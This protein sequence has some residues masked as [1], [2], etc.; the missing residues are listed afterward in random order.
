MNR[1]SV[2][3]WSGSRRLLRE[4]RDLMKAESTTQVRLDQV[5]AM[6]ASDMVAEVC[7]VYLM[8]AGEV[9]ELYAS[10]G[11]K[12]EAV[13]RTR[14][15]LGEG[16]VGHIALRARPVALADAQSH[17][18][19]AYRPETGEEIYHS[20][21]GVPLLRDNRVQGVLVVQNVTARSY[22]EEEV[23]ALETVAMVLSELIVSAGILTEDETRH[24]EGAS[25]VPARL[26]GITLNDGIGM[27][28]AVPHHRGIV[29][30]Q[31]VAEDPG[32]E[33]LRLETALDEMLGRLEHLIEKQDLGGA[34]E[35]QDI[36]E[37]YRM[38]AKDRGWLAR[39]E[40]AVR[41][42]LTAEAAVQKI[43]TDTRSRMA[44]VK[45]PYIR[46]RYAD[47]E[48][49]GNRLLQQL[50]GAKGTAQEDDLPDDMVLVARSL[51]PADLLDYDRSRLR[52]VV[53]EEGAPTAHVAIVARALGV[54][55]VGR[56]KDLLS[57]VRPGDFMIADA[58][59]GQVF[60]RPRQGVR[61]S[62]SEALEA[63]EARKA[64]Q[65]ASRDQ[66][67]RTRD[68]TRI[69]LMMNAGLLIDV[70]QLPSSGA[71]GIG[72]FRTE[73]PF[74][75][76]EAFPDVAVQRGF[77]AR[78]Y[79]IAAGLPTTFRT[80]DVGGD[81]ALPYWSGGEDDNPAMGW[82]AIRIGLDRPA[83]L[84]QQLR[85]LIGAAAGRELRVMFPMVAEVAEFT[86]ARRILAQEL[87][88]GRAAGREAP[89]DLKVGAM[90]EV[91]ALAWQLPALL[92]EVDFLSV[93]S[94]DL[95]Q[96]LFASDRGNPRLARRYDALS[97]PV[98][99]FFR[100]LT[101]S[102]DAAG[103]PLSICGEMAAHPLDAMA[104]LGC[105]FRSLSMPMSGI[106]PVKTMLC[107]LDLPALTAY[108]EGLEGSAGH[109]LRERLRGYAL[110]RGIAI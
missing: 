75:V 93:G 100:S 49:L 24:S 89:S 18:E 74:M 91:P 105:G 64:A 108:M 84:R 34:G 97:P 12:P 104:L 15:R 52:A 85:A 14:L 87:A 101:R 45:D 96:F 81:K 53:L 44:K 69:S 67:P 11:L 77:Y 73:V 106:G 47:L 39:I 30:S 90:L 61:A 42:G 55:M 16:L 107:S 99:N 54:P 31:V 66:E 70:S 58:E 83:M 38:F 79:E 17:P 60:L 94:N 72:L 92:R 102:A 46:E 6:I 8:R 9:L 80:L 57:E 109:S 62:F 21:L 32:A 27:G 59:N 41:D 26:S 98:L 50:L 76:R 43:Q 7:S 48:D 23:E 2:H 5:V 95:V 28:Y 33:V 68:G 36:L 37:T 63:R 65:A 22:G 1:H 25:V 29:I 71:E 86:A 3:E 103:V 35:H 51:G 40:E 56:C 78:V 88:H 110:D 10:K 82:R 20:L 4:L 19:F 13:H